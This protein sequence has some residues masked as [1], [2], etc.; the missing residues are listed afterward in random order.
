M[1]WRQSVLISALLLCIMSASAQQ[2][3]YRCVGTHG[4]LVFRDQPCRYAGLAKLGAPKSSSVIATIAD[5]E[6]AGRCGFISEP[7]SFV[8]PLLAQSKLR[9]QIDIDDEGP[10]LTIAA[11]GVYQIGDRM[12]P[13]TF[14]SRLGSQGLQIEGDYFQ[15]A[16]W[17]M[18]QQTLGFGRSRMRR[19]LADLSRVPATVVVWFEGLEQAVQSV[20]IPPESLREAVDNTRRCWKTR[21]PEVID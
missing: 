9:L 8:E 21:T 18:G 17:R 15:A 13:A 16:E 1:V 11:E 2:R 20:S 4:E 5:E 3:V 6:H 7:L 10:Y 19:L 14:D 12:L